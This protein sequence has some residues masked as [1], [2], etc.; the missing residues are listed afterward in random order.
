MEVKQQNTATTIWVSRIF[1]LFLF[2]SLQISV[3]LRT[4]GLLCR[5]AV[6]IQKNTGGLL[7]GF[8]MGNVLFNAW[9]KFAQITSKKMPWSVAILK[10]S[11]RWRNERQ[12]ERKGRDGQFSMLWDT[13][14]AYHYQ[15]NVLAMDQNEKLRINFTAVFVNSSFWEH[16]QA[17]LLE[18]R[19]CTGTRVVPQKQR[20]WTELSLSFM[21]LINKALK[22]INL[23]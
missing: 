12:G 6:Q 14:A 13:L 23:L 10:V 22:L 9:A 8:L 17:Y 4:T 2:Q 5:V 11:E 16:L 3:M 21:H 18:Y 20:T 19:E 1:A 7:K 15:E